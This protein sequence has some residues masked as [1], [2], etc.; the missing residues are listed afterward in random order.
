MRCLREADAED[1][2]CPACRLGDRL[3]LSPEAFSEDR[4]VDPRDFP[5]A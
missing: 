4:F 2:L 1:L 3:M 5:L